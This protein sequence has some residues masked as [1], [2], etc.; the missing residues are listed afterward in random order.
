M[1]AR[2]RISAILRR[3]GVDSR[4]AA[5]PG[6]TLV[7]ILIAVGALALIAVGIS[8]VFRATGDTVRAGRRISNLNA[9]ASL[10]ERQLRDDFSKITRDGFLLIRNERIWKDG[11]PGNRELVGA[12]ARNAGVPLV[13]GHDASSRPRRAD[14]IMFF[15]TGDFVTKRPPAIP[16]RV[17]R[18][19]AARIYIGHGLRRDPK[20]PAYAAPVQLD[21]DNTTT[22]LAVA[23]PLTLGMSG[24]NGTVGPNQAAAEWT[25]L[26]HVTLLTPPNPAK[27]DGVVPG[28]PG[29]PLQNTRLLDGMW[30]IA[31]QPAVRSIFRSFNG[32]AESAYSG[33]APH[34]DEVLHRG[35]VNLPNEGPSFGCGAIDIATTDL[36]EIRALIHAATTINDPATGWRGGLPGDL[37]ARKAIEIQDNMMAGWP[38]RVPRVVQLIP[39]TLVGSAVEI[40]QAWMRDALPVDSDAPTLGSSNDRGGRIRYEPAPPNPLCLDI[41]G[42]GATFTPPGAAG[43]S[44]QREMERADQ[45]MLS[46]HN[47]VPGCSEFIVE[48]SWGD[49]Y[50][51]NDPRVGQIIWHGLERQ[52]DIDGNGRSSNQL[53]ERIATTYIDAITPFR[54]RFVRRDGSIGE[55]V[56]PGLLVNTNGEGTG[57]PG[58]DGLDNIQYNYFGYINPTYEPAGNPDDPTDPPPVPNPGLLVDV[59]GNGRYDPND[60]DKYND[61]E[62]IPWPW[63]RLIRITMSLVDPSDPT[64]EQTY[65]F[66]FDLPGDPMDP[67]Y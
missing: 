36:T 6:F 10:I 11:D 42:A 60:G 38:T 33:F 65:Q 41:P 47:F 19:P 25:L 62:V 1:S 34:A 59:N 31:G 26:R 20:H 39:G 27:M 57:Y 66:I 58:T 5:G 44:V 51:S 15:V 3:A 63:P 28:L 32:G 49:T 4:A 13:P 9:Y 16:D 45:L 56:V 40:M 35:L 2:E 55:R 67:R 23:P 43:Q 50:P 48:W 22:R 21:D 18:A 53:E 7:E 54:Q 17:A 61:P 12:N 14:E 52:V 24:P 8:Q 46:A 29:S 37:D 30:Q 64:I